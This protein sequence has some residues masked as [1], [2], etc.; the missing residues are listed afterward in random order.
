MIRLL[1]EKELR[2]SI[3]S[4]RWVAAFAVCAVLIVTAFGLGAREHRAAVARHEAAVAADLR[5]LDGLTDW[6]NIRN[7][8][9]FL[10]PQP[11]DA[12]V[13]GVAHDIGRTAVVRGRGTPLPAG[14][15]YG[16]EPL[17]ATFR[18]LD[19]EFLF[20]VVLSL[21]VV[22]FAH[23]A[24]SGEKERGTLR[25]ALAGAVPRLTLVL[26][27]LGGVIASL[28]LPVLVPVLA[29]CLLLPTF[30]VHLSGDEWLRLACIVGAGLA[31]LAVFATAAVLVSALTR[32]S[33]TSF[34]VLL[35]FWIVSVLIVPRTGVLLAGRVVPV[36][37][38]VEVNAELSRLSAQLVA[39]T[40]QALAAFRPSRPE[41]P[42]SAMAEVQQ[43]MTRLG[44]GRQ[45]ALDE[46]SGRLE[47]E[48]AAGQTA[49]QRLALGLARVSPAAAFTLAATTLAGTSLELPRRF[50]EQA[51]AYQ[52]E[53]ARFIF[54]KTGMNPGGAMMRRMVIGGAAPAAI[55]PAELP[56]FH[57]RSPRLAELLPAALGNVALLALAAVLF[58]A[59]AVVAFA[60]YD[61]R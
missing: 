5:Q 51:V 52:A 55:N 20:Q 58:A 15:R 48:R 4:A 16:E 59:G 36:R 31:Y 23:D 2:E 33:A 25:L 41:D 21:F 40:D 6:L 12:L 38:S 18:F 57:F 3:H 14:S 24:I 13:G 8:R 17:L 34:L 45:R 35:V 32:R 11:L 27:K 37:P 29:G 47:E 10:P 9:I 42:Q 26:G 44:E 19:L 28:V 53:Y 61:A 46:L 30:G 49:R 54:A 43:L 56:Q 7:H 39:E 50:R 60:R 22:V 1:I